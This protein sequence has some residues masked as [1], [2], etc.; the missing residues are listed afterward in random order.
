MNKI[1]ANF[2]LPNHY[3]FIE[4]LTLFSWKI[5]FKKAC[6]YCR[7]FEKKQK[8]M[9]F[10]LCIKKVNKE[11]TII[12]DSLK[13]FLKAH[14]IDLVCFFCI[15]FKYYFFSTLLPCLSSTTLYPADS[16]SSLIVSAKIKSLDCFAS[17]LDFSLDSISDEIS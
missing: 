5:L 17:F 8:I 10:L 6:I 2:I 13:I 14:H 7:F 11:N 12:T 3:L 1:K 4:V 9:I 15:Y 16:I